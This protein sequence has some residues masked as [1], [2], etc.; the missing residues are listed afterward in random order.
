[1]GERLLKL[2]RHGH[3]AVLTLNRPEHRNTV[4]YGVLDAMLALV[5]DVDRD[6]DVRVVVLTG[7]GEFFSAGTDLSARDGFRADG[8]DFTPLR[9]G[10]RDVGGELSI[11]FFD[12]RTPP[13][14]AV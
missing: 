9:G 12:A 5:D 10:T 6:D 4:T 13:I 1:M 3:V 11:R 14:A 2:E 7:E 8:S